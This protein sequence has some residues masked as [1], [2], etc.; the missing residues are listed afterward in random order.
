MTPAD[1]PPPG[2]AEAPLRGRELLVC[3]CGGIAAFKVAQVVSTVVQLGCGV[4]VAMTRAARRFVGPVTFRALSGRPVHTSMWQ[5]TAGDIPHLKLTEQA[6]LLLVA[7]AT[8]NILG[9]LAGGIADDLVSSLLL[10][11]ACP[12]L[13]APAMNTRMWAHPAVVRNVEFLR[14]SGFR[15]IG[16]DSGW[17]ACRADGP[18]RMSEADAIVAEIQTQL[19]LLPPRTAP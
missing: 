12:V 16:P 19:A 5:E 18:G 14:S 6:D 10:G 4:R 7:P 15:F 2:N 13:L 11:A 9:K 8:A 17:Q 1:C 3:V